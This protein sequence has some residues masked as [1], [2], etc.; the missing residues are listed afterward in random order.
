MKSRKLSWMKSWV[1]SYLQLTFNREPFIK[2]NSPFPHFC[3]STHCAEL[4][5]TVK[6]LMKNSFPVVRLRIIW[7]RKESWKFPLPFSFHNHCCIYYICSRI[8]KIFQYTFPILFPPRY[9]FNIRLTSSIVLRDV[10]RG[11]RDTT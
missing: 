4:S 6:L 9:S 2:A 7:K 1:F 3:S 5:W 10:F 8:W 11:I